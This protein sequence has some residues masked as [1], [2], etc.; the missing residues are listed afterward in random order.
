MLPW[1]ILKCM[2]SWNTWKK[3]AYLT[4]SHLPGGILLKHAVAVRLIKN[5]K[6]VIKYCYDQKFRDKKLR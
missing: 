5:I 4:L 1:H 3:D 6:I 2:N